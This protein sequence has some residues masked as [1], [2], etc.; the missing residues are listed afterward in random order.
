MKHQAYSVMD[1]CAGTYLMPMFFLNNASAIRA[2]GDA[3]NRPK[4]DNQF[5]Q[6]PE[7]FQLYKIGEFDDDHGIFEGHPPMFVVSCNDLVRV[8]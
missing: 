3:V 2:L 7:H 4:E 8:D 6:H 5:Y 1:T